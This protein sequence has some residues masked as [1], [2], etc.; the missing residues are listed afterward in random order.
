M[1]YDSVHQYSRRANRNASHDGAGSSSD[2]D[3]LG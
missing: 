2:D 1:T 3:H